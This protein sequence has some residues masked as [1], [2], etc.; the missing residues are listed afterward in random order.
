LSEKTLLA[1][2]LLCGSLFALE[3]VEKPLHH[4]HAGKTRISFTVSGVD[5]TGSKQKDRGTTYAV[6]A[7]WQNRHHHVQLLY[8][9][10][11]TQTFQPP[12]PDDLDVDKYAGRYEYAFGA[13]SRLNASYLHVSDNLAPTDGGHVYGLGF[14]YK[15]LNFTQYISDYDDFDV[16]QS[17]L[18]VGM[19]KT[20]S[21][22]TLFGMLNAKYIYIDDLDIPFTANAQRSYFTTLLNLHLHYG[23]F[24]CNVGGF[25]GKRAFAVLQN[26][27][28]VQHHAM[29]FQYTA[30]AGAGYSFGRYALHLRYA[31]HEATELVI[32]NEGVGIDVLT[33]QFDLSF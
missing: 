13:K 23:G 16:Y 31:H 33:A 25:L 29:E 32:D 1:S 15:P 3:S 24:H 7:D 12:L 26:G 8:L 9:H 30:M 6:G 2:L 5:Y 11:H 20:F 4:D 10:N 18:R 21:D 22:V 28:A 27:L 19:K 17:D 14:T